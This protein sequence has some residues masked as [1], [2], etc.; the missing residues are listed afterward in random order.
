[1]LEYSLAILFAIVVAPYLHEGSHWFI[2]WLGKT[3][4]EFAYVLWIFPNGVQ[5][6]EIKTMDSEIIRFAGVAPL[7]WIPV[8]FLG[9]CLFVLERSSS[10]L[11]L[12]SAPLLCILMSTESDALA[13]REPEQYRE[14]VMHG[15]LSREPIL[16]PDLPKWIP[17]FNS[18]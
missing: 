2:G 15:E 13:F 8:A 14:E 17:R 6:G 12:A 9:I 7:L 1:M 3:K 10:I 16:L 11:F 4:P 5:H 18:R